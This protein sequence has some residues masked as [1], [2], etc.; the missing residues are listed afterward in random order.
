MLQF[1][2]LAFAFALAL[3]GPAIATAQAQEPEPLHEFCPLYVVFFDD[4]SAELEPPAKEIIDNW[5][6]FARMFDDPVNRF[7]IEATAL[8][9]SL[10][11]S[12]KL[13]LS[14]RRGQAVATYLQSKGFSPDRM[15]VRALGSSGQLWAD[16]NS[17]S[18]IDRAQNRR[19]ILILETTESNWKKVPS[20]AVC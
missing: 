4:R 8:D 9:A 20:G 7:T 16:P 18:D 2:Q 14:F 11:A 17:A 13:E 3:D 19:A 10:S 12:D 15:R 1:L 6:S 5:I